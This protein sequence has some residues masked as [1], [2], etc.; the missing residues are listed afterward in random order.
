[1]D[2]CF[3]RSTDRRDQTIVTRQDGVR[4]S[5]P[6]YGPLEPLPHDLAHYV[7]EREFSLRDG[8]WASVAGGAILKGMK[9]ISGRQPPH[10]RE[11]SDAIQAANRRGILFAELAVDTVLRAITGEPLRDEPYVIESQAVSLRTKADYIVLAERA[12]PAMEA[13]IARWQAVP[14]GETFVVSWPDGQASRAVIPKR[15][16]HQG[17]AGFSRARSA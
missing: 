13:M 2:I 16:S 6:V 11:R 1:M 9:T 15:R 10:A 12:R 8:L 5:V 4:L 7:V 17:R 14:I 3:M